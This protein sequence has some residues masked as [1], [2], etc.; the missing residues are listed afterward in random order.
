M[1]IFGVLLSANI[2]EVEY[3]NALGRIIGVIV[4]AL[5]DHHGADYLTVN[6]YQNGKVISTAKST[7]IKSQHALIFTR[8]KY[9]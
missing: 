7:S 4:N 9:S 1:D 5:V 3:T 2:I 8:F 6:M